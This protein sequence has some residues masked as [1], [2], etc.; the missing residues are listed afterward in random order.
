VLLQELQ[1]CQWPST[2]LLL[3]FLRALVWGA[4]LLA[5][6]CWT[7]QGRHLLLLLL[8]PVLALLQLKARLEQASEPG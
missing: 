8:Q 4:A 7:L 2:L 1:P 3:P 5:L 6:G